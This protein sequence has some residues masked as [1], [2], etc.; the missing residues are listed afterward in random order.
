[1]DLSAMVTQVRRDLRDEDSENYVWSDDE[2]ERHIAHAL[3]D[4]SEQLPRQATATLSTVSGSMDLDVSSLIDVIVINAVE[5]PT[6]YNP[7]RYQRFSAWGDTLM[8]L[9]SLVPDGSNCTIYYGKTHT[10]DVDGTTL[11]TKYHDILALGAQGYALLAWGS[12][13][14]NRVN[15]GGPDVASEYRHSGELHLN[16]FYRD[17]KRLGRRHRAVVSRLYTPTEEPVSM[18]VDPG[19]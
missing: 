7:K 19:P 9:G 16:L 10:L 13:S 12:Y 14:V 2:L 11:P 18:D 4:L 17:I 1:M 15:L 8:F 6:A 3:Y 5:Y